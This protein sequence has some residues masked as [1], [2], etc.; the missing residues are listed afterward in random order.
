[1]SGQASYIDSADTFFVM[2]AAIFTSLLSEGNHY[3][4]WLS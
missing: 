3:I 2:G 1:M 4:W